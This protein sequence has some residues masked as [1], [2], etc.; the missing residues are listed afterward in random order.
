MAVYTVLLD[1]EWAG[2]LMNDDRLTL[3][4]SPGTHN[5]QLWLVALRQSLQG[6]VLSFSID[7]AQSLA[8]ECEPEGGFFDAFFR[9]CRP[10]SLRQTTSAAAS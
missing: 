7:D 5:L 8:F 9:P 6:N 2:S 3:Q 10:L 4:V 1:G